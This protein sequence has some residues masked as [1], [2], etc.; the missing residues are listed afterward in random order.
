[1]PFANNSLTF[2]CPSNCKVAGQV[3]NP[4]A[5]GTEV[6]SYSSYVIGGPGG[7]TV[8][9]TTGNYRADS[10]ICPAAIHAGLV[11]ERYGGCGIMTRTGSSNDY[12]SSHNAGIRS[13]GFDATFPSSY[14]FTTTFTS[15][16][17]RDLRYHLFAV[18]IPFTIA[19]SILCTHPA[20][21]YYTLFTTLFFH[22]ALASDPPYIT[23]PDGLVS[24]ALSRYLPAIFIAHTLWTFV[25]AR[26]H[27]SPLLLTT[28]HV[29]RTILFLGG[30][31]VGALN[32]F[33]FD[34]IIPISRLTGIDLETQPGAKA[35]LAVV[36]IVLF[37]I[38][39]GQVHFF[40]IS[41]RLPGM[42]GLY[43]GVGV[44]LGLLAAIPGNSL[45]IHHYILALLL[46]PGTKLLT[47]PSLLYQG[48]LLGLFI[49]GIARWGF[50]G[51]VETPIAIIGD[52]VSYTD[53]P[54]F[55][56][57]DVARDNVTVHWETEKDSEWEGVSVLVNDV[58]RVRWSAKG[59]TEGSAV[60][61][62]IDGEKTYLRLGYYKFT[63]EA[64]DYTRAGVV[65]VNGTWEEPEEGWT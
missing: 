25:F 5:V 48:L 64:G 65:W 49:N 51:I 34:V 59:E 37:F 58:E 39:V 50:A 44:G 27:N 18:S 45:R 2:R 36:C 46:L 12:P 62:R 15:T 32:N 31:W 26:I 53:L 9:G 11:S 41:G 14:G 13:I 21:T 60:I 56:P 10:F 20:T 54:T 6:V 17:C 43:A 16:S 3:L 29:E 33:T 47:R 57:P 40:R 22:V 61:D 63:G 19:L 52:G 8:P 55:I 7:E 38:V 24:R 23:N 28:A 1:M 30:L 35:A 4:R 42:L